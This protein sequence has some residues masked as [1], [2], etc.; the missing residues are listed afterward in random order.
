MSETQRIRRCAYCRGDGHNIVE[1]D[2]PMV[3]IFV[4]QFCR[5]AGQGDMEWFVEWSSNQFTRDALRV[6]VA[7]FVLHSYSRLP[8]H[9]L[10]RIMVTYFEQFTTD[11]FRPERKDAEYENKPAHIVRAINF[12]RVAFIRKFL[13]SHRIPA[14]RELYLTDPREEMRSFP[15]LWLNHRMYKTCE[16]VPIAKTHIHRYSVATRTCPFPFFFKP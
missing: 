12:G 4:E 13:S 8:I 2:V 3:Q 1:C 14:L 10:I 6:I 11:I 15:D 16:T 5:V 9:E 7:K